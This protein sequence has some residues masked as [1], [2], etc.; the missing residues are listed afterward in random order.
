[1]KFLVD[2]CAGR[3]IGQW[4]KELGHD[5]IFV[6]D[7]NPRMGDEEILKWANNEGRILITID[8]DFGYYILKFRTSLNL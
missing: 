2:V 5:I 3:A 4:L 1:M 6:R 8:K 7:Y